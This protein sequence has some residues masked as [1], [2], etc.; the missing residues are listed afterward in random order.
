MSAS[1]LVANLIHHFLL[2]VTRLII[3]K[4]VHWSGL[5]SHEDS[6]EINSAT[7]DND[8]AWLA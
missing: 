6:T 7:I 8:V 4:E 2:A 1:D 3:W 5:F